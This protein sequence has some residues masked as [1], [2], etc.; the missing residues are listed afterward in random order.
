[1]LRVLVCDGRYS[2]FNVVVFLKCSPSDLCC[3][4]QSTNI[5]IG[6]AGVGEPCILERLCN[7]C[8][9]NHRPDYYSHVWTAFREPVPTVNAS[10]NWEC[11][12]VRA[13]SRATHR[14]P[15]RTHSLHRFKKCLVSCICYT[16]PACIHPSDKK[17]TDS[18]FLILVSSWLSPTQSA[19]ALRL[20][21]DEYHLPSILYI[22]AIRSC[23]FLILLTN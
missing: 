12:R 22:N 8:G 19:P 16:L 9:N 4:S 17:I 21:S 23:Y 14:T 2:N 1:M 6:G 5:E 18:Y 20:H 11:A 13:T 10:N 7:P 15:P 3:Y